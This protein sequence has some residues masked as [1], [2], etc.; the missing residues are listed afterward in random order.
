MTSPDPAADGRRRAARFL[1]LLT[2]DDAA[3][4]ELLDSLAEVRDLV[5]LGAG[6][7]AVARAEARFLPPAQ[8]IDHGVP[9]KGD[10]L[11]GYPLVD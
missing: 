4:G 1:A 11:F 6:L 7:T 2:A 9:H 5:F 3:A 8:R 10:S